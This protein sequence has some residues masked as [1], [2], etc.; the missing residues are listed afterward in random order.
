M[1]KK[2]RTELS[3]LAINTNLPDN[4]QELI[5]PTT[6]RA[7]LTDERESVVNYKDDLG[8]TTNA[9]KFLTVATDG[10]SLTMVDAPTGD[11]TGT[12]VQYQVAVWD[13]TNSLTGNAAFRFLT[14]AQN[15]IKLTRGTGSGNILF[16][17]ADGTTLHGYIENQ[18]SGNGLTIGQQDGSTSAV[19]DLDDSTITFKT[20]NNTALTISSTGETT[21]TATSTSG[22]IIAQTGQSYYH[23]IRN[24]GDGLYI[25]ADDG[26][27]GGAGA[28]MRFAV[29]GIEAMRITSAG[30]TK[31]KAN[32]GSSFDTGTYNEILNNNNTSGATTLIIGN[33]GGSAT[34]NASSTMLLCHDAVAARAKILGN[35]NLVN[36]NNSYGQI[37]DIKL[38]ENIKDATP[39]LDHLL[40]VKIRNFNLI[41]SDTK[42]IGVIAQELEEVFPSMIDDS[43]DWEKQE[44]TDEEGN[45][46]TEQVDSG[47]VTKSVKYSV[48]VP[49]LV[50]A[51]QEQ[52]TIIDS[53]I[54]RLEALEV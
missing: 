36:A 42:Q 32:G 50:K 8:G 38:K 53:L 16:Y 27:Q 20:D 12:G 47:T 19:I 15:S 2:T 5:T 41:G 22:L 45:I 33:N 25:G 34:N 3:T 13:G 1:A 11:V 29:K 49:I 48:F 10:E 54:T 6:E 39:K 52:Q 28:D 44:V 24:Q 17:A 30:F 40:K 31:I 35:G 9:G 23:K 7:Q 21:I 37:S 51:I 14:G 46:T 4:T 26:G 43:I 18:V